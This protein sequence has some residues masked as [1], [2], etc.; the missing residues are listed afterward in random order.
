MR[1]KKFFLPILAFLGLLV[2]LYMVFFGTPKV[3]ASPI[4]FPPPVS[5]YTN[6]IAGEGMVEASSLNISIGSPYTEIITDVYVM[7]GDKVK[8][9]APLFKVDDRTFRA[10]LDFE[11]AQE[12]IALANLNRLLAQPRP[13]EVPPVEAQLKGTEYSYASAKTHLDLFENVTDKRA[14]SVDEL[15]TTRFNERISFF[16]MIQAQKQLDLL[17]AGAWSKDID[18]AKAELQSAQASR[19]IAEVNL[20]RTVI[21]APV[22]G[23]VLQ[24]NIRVGESISNSPAILATVQSLVPP[25]LFG[26]VEPLQLRVDVDENEAWRIVPNT[27]ATAFVRGNRSISVPLRY[28]RIEPYIIPKSSF[29]GETTERVDTRVLQVI[30]QF[31]KKGLPIYTGQIMDVFIEAP[32]YH[33]E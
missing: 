18:I 1:K 4:L 25:I 22:D 16:A 28:I 21:R 5:P 29:T 9:N 17:N 14:V 7:P 32:S 24:V 30:Y 11:K 13:E 23:E 27:A 2:T 10:Q 19:R 3:P 31:D 15:N 6:S 33:Y 26:S 20:L 12:E 8:K